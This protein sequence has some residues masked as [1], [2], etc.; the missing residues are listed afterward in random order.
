LSKQSTSDH[1]REP[2]VG[3]EG[4][5]E[6]GSSEEGEKFVARGASREGVGEVEVLEAGR[7][8]RV[9]GDGVKGEMGKGL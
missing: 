3:G 4:G 5:D 7:A 1:S 6:T 2:E 9:E 8:E